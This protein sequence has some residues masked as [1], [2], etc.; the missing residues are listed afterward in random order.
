MTARTCETVGCEAPH[1]CRGMCKPCYRRDYY[2]RNKERESANF[3]AYREAN[4]EAEKARWA[5]YAEE[6]WGEE[7]REREA[8][9]R[10]AIESPVKT[11]TKCDTEKP[12][13]DFHA[14][15]R[16]TD[17]LHSWCKA[18][19]AAHQR[20]AEARNPRQRSPEHRAK[21]A[22]RLRQWRKDNP[23]RA[24]MVAREAA[25]RRRAPAGVKVDYDRILER[26]GMVCHICGDDIAD[27]SDLHFDHVI[28]LSK[29]GPHV[30]SNIRP[31]HAGCNM[32][33]RA[34]ILESVR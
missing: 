33:K 7:R 11:C 32:R 16:R 18:C 12:K 20:E 31:S 26:D 22:E 27:R 17:G 15:P 24:R 21:G 4:A 10:A 13:D 5:K 29:G 28:P 9:R 6:R 30:E 14:D 25:G 2:R 1:Y 8:A 23:E 3:R 34:R 19:F